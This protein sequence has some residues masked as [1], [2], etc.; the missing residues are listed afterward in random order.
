[1]VRG[2]KAT[3][4]A[5]NLHVDNDHNYIKKGH[6]R[7]EHMKLIKQTPFV[8]LVDE[9]GIFLHMSLLDEIVE[10]WSK[11]EQGFMLHNTLIP[12]TRSNI[13]LILSLQYKGMKLHMKRL[14]DLTTRYKLFLG[15]DEV[16]SQKLLEKKIENLALLTASDMVLDTVRC[17]MEHILVVSFLPKGPNT[18]RMDYGA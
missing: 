1:M 12:F 14:L 9:V 11:D 15:W 16:V 6:M 3:S 18:W 4:T 2:E 8:Q 13:T 10:F 7:D 5:V 17:V